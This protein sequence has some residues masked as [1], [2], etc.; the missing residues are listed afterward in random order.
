[1]IGLFNIAGSFFA[2]WSGQH[3]SKKAVLSGI[4]VA[5]AVVISLFVLVP[6][7]EVSVLVFS[8]VMG[9]LWLSTVPLTMGLVAQTQGLKIL[10]SVVRF[11]PWAPF[12]STITT[13]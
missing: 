12:K 4:Y 9:L 7:T 10:V 1:L 13:L 5:R 8:A 6:V 11:R 3:L 2:G